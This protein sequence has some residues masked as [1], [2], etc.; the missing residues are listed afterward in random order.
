MLNRDNTIWE[1]LLAYLRSQLSEREFTTWFSH[2]K[3][4]GIQEGAFVIGVSG[5]FARD[6][7]RDNYL[8]EIEAGLKRLGAE[9]PRVGLHV[10][11]LD[12]AREHVNLELTEATTHAE[13]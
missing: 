10:L 1:E 7:I 2:A 4:V 6:W 8:S 5:S 3:P 11:P 9:T 12:E 13:P